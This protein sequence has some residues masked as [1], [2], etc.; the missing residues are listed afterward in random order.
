[1]GC[2][3]LISIGNLQTDRQKEGQTHNSHYNIDIKGYG[4]V[5][6]LHFFSIFLQIALLSPFL[7]ENFKSVLKFG[8][9]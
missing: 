5:K 9:G 4:E 1:M 3:V 6:N 7:D 2:L 8:I